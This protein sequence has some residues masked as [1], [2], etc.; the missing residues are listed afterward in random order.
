[1]TKNNGQSVDVDKH[2]AKLREDY[3]AKI[4]EIKNRNKKGCRDQFFMLVLLVI[5]FVSL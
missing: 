4:D 1:M 5:T 3:I 2:V